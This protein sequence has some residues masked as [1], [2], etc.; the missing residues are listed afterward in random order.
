MT[1]IYMR[2][3]SSDS[4][5]LPYKRPTWFHN[6]RNEF[7]ALGLWDTGSSMSA[8]TYRLPGHKAGV[9]SRGPPCSGMVESGSD[10]LTGK[11][12]TGRHD[13]LSVEMVR[14]T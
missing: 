7:A 10:I 14:V 3:A 1:K 6:F 13:L 5:P 9:R 4:L 8:N 12:S 2:E 11:N